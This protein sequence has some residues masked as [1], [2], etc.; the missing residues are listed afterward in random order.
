MPRPRSSAARTC[1]ARPTTCACQLDDAKALLG[2]AFEELKKVE[3]LD[4]R[5][6]ARERAEENARE[7]ADMDQHRPDARP[8]RRHRLKALRPLVLNDCQARARQARVFLML[9]SADIGGLVLPLGQGAIE[10]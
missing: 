7:Q 2:E 9:M 3:L 10:A 4:E 1:R 6:Q 8:P 5:D